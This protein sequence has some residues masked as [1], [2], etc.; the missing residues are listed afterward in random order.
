MRAMLP[1][2]VLA[3][4]FAAAS[5]SAECPPAEQAALEKL[6]RDWGDAV[7]AGDRAK[8]ESMLADD[9]RDLSPD[10]G[11]NKAQS[12]DAALKNAE[13]A[14]ANP[15]GSTSRSDHYAIQCSATGATIVHRGV[16]EGKDAQG[17]PWS[18]HRRA[19]HTLEKRDGR[20]Q[21]VATVGTRLSDGDLL[22]YLELDWAKA[23]VA[24]AADWIAQNYAEDFSGVSSRTGKFNG[25]AEDLAE[26]KSPSYKATTASVHDMGVR[27]HGDVAVVTG[28][29]H[30][31]GTDKDG[32]PYD[33]RIAFTDT[34]KKVDGRWL[35]WASQGTQ[36]AD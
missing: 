34:W 30:S 35:V 24:G 8:L 6:D 19:A 15:D 17:K 20:W 22:R 18:V 25:K 14:K 10:G 12:I 3:M 26:A 11:N 5:V 13:A 27:M 1:M 23:D 9:F 32:K 16:F 29:Y 28:E 31:T 2:A 4:T 21:V 7:E 36:I 33:R